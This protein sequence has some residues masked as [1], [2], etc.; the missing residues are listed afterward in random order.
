[1]PSSK[2]QWPAVMTTLLEGETTEVPEQR[3]KPI[4]APSEMKI[5]PLTRYPGAVGSAIVSEVEVRVGLSAEA[6][7]TGS[8][9]TIGSAAFIR[10]GVQNERASAAC[11]GKAIDG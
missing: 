10:S 3:P 8:G 5:T 9:P 2:T 11:S 6:W 4:P 1:M 7:A